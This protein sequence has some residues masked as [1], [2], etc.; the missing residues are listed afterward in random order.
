[1]YVHNGMPTICA[2]VFI[3]IGMYI[4]LRFHIVHKYDTYIRTVPVLSSSVL[5]TLGS[6]YGYG[7]VDANKSLEETRCRYGM[8]IFPSTRTQFAICSSI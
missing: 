3:H 2:W 1:M 8:N 5:S 4:S 7:I 6:G